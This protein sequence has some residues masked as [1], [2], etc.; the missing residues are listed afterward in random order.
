M[1]IKINPNSDCG[2]EIE[3]LKDLL[4]H[5]K[6]YIAKNFTNT[7]VVSIAIDELFDR[8]NAEKSRGE[9]QRSM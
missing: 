9:N 2:T 4:R 1:N 7:E 5:N 3:L 8:L 6:R